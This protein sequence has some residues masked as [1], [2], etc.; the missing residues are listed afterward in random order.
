MH[1]VPQG[2]SPRP[3]CTSRGSRK[4]CVPGQQRK[5]TSAGETHSFSPLNIWVLVFYLQAVIKLLDTLT[6]DVDL[7]PMTWNIISTFLSPF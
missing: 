2:Q 4:A 7:D 1:A 5:R 3:D 6:A